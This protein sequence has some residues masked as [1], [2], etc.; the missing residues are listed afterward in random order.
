MQARVL[1]RWT[2]LA[3]VGLVPVACGDDTAEPDDREVAAF[4]ERAPRPGDR[5]PA[6]YVG[7]DEHVADLTELARI[8]PEDIAGDVALV[9]EHF[10]TSVDPEDP[11]SQLTENFPPHV[12]EAIERIEAF[13][14]TECAQPA[15]Q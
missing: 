4:C 12:R 7:S 6:E 9:R 8:A 2:G 10:D 11:E 5:E 13:V 1:A 15:E 14:R 3:L